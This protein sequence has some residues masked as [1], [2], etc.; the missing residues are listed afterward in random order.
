MTKY[1][2]IIDGLAAEIINFD[3][4]GRYP[5]HFEWV[6]CPDDTKP[7]ATYVGGVFAN[8][9]TDTV[10]KNEPE[11]VKEKV[12]NPVAFMGL[13]TLEE[14]VKMRAFAEGT[15]ASNLIVREL[16][17]VL[18]HPALVSINVF[19]PDVQ[20]GLSLFV[21]TGLLTEER[22]TEIEA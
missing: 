17:R 20:A 3:P 18:D 6:E 10:E 15:E 1:A 8:P 7:N 16:L 14:R 11:V 13:F 5:D 2:R 19:A 21:S 12:L 9:V 4:D 22:K